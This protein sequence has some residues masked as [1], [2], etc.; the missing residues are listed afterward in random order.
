MHIT[1]AKY[2]FQ[3]RQMTPYPISCDPNEAKTQLI[4]LIMKIT[5]LK[6]D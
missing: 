6:F 4:Q 1:S 3:M 5:F 2:F